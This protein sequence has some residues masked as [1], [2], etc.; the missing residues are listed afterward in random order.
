MSGVICDPPLI[1][2]APDSD[3]HTLVFGVR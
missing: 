1:D 3:E 2:I